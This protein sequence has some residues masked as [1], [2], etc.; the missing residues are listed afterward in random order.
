MSY[1]E[2]YQLHPYRPGTRVS[3]PPRPTNGYDSLDHPDHEP[4]TYDELSKGLI[5]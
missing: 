3:R 4:D 5:T 2:T 1:P